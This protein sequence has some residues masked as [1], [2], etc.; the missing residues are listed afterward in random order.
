MEV[1]GDTVLRFVEKPDAKTAAE[2]VASGRFFWN[3]GMFCFPARTMIA[4]MEAL[5][6]R[7]A[8][9]REGGAGDGPGKRS[10]ADRTSLE[11][12]KDSFAQ[13]PAISIDYAVMEK[14]RNIG[15]VPCTFG[16]SD[17][18]SWNAMSE[19]V[20]ADASGNR[21]TGEAL[22]HQSDRLLRA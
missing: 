3:S 1:E 11:I 2:Y 13:V 7:R 17:I 18:G 19:M 21:V 5:V 22:L 14:A 6:P 16:W 4:G 20:P 8:G 10:P 12:D 9:R 15:F